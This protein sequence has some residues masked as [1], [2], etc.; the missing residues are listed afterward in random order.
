MSEAPQ[1]NPDSSADANSDADQ[2][3]SE[4][5]ELR[6]QSG[7]TE[8]TTVVQLQP[9]RYQLTMHYLGHDRV[10][11][12]DDYRCFYELQRGESPIAAFPELLQNV[13]GPSNTAT[14]SINAALPAVEGGTP[15]NPAGDEMFRVMIVDNHAATRAD[16]DAGFFGRDGDD[17]SKPDS[18]REHNWL[19]DITPAVPMRIVVKKYIGNTLVDFD[20][21]LKAIVEVKD[22][23][24]ELDNNAGQ[25]QT[26]LDEFFTKFN[27]TDNDPNIGDDNALSGFDGIRTG[28]ASEAG[29]KA[30]DVLRDV[31][32][33]SPPTID[34]APVEADLI[35]FSDLN[36]AP[37]H[38]NQRAKFTIVARD[39]DDGVKVGITDIAFV[40]APVGGDNYRFLIHLVCGNQDLRDTQEHGAA[41]T[42]V[43]QSNN[44][45]PK[46]QCYT[47]GRFVI[48][49]KADMRLIVMANNNIPEH[50]DWALVERIFNKS[51]LYVPE[52]PADR[53]VNLTRAAWRAELRRELD[54]GNTDPD[55]DNDANFTEA[56]YNTMFFPTA[57]HD[58]TQRRS[59]DNIAGSIIR[60]ACDNTSPPISPAPDEDTD[61]ESLPGLFMLLIKKGQN[62]PL[63]NLAGVYL[64]DRR[65]WF[66][67]LYNAVTDAETGV[68]TQNHRVNVTSKIY[69]HEYGHGL[70]L[71]HSHTNFPRARYTDTGGNTTNIRLTDGR[72]NN[73][74]RDHD[75]VDAYNCLMGYAFPST[76]V[77]CGLCS[78]TL[79]MFDRP[80]IAKRNNYGDESMAS[81]SPARVVHFSGTTQVSGNPVMNLNE[82]IPNLSV[83]STMDLI[84]CGPARQF[85]TGSS[86]TARTGRV[87]I[88]FIPDASTWVQTGG[89]SGSVSIGFTDTNGDNLNNRVRVTGVSPGVVT[90]RCTLDGITADGTFTVVE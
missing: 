53:F 15:E 88:S 16:A 4:S 73:N 17:W 70:Y 35:S 33:Q 86:N 48:W 44:I 2:Q 11:H 29:V 76:A 3:Q 49:K 14:E 32:Y 67:S 59:I 5:E 52:P 36:D 79:R 1:N 21:D 31:N 84:A 83:G 26:Y 89:G 30:T 90:V 6:S 78:L 12:C 28:S 81:L 87:N 60:H 69:A 85:A 42:V 19:R 27:R 68:V 71:R 20:A 65:F 37:S 57:I 7:A 41:V 22:P 74:L 72:R 75:Q 64:G 25:Q 66:A 62:S 13:V 56:I 39:N 24:E 45:I 38:A 63:G 61:Q 50:I 8:Q 82:T 55:F 23:V 34:H 40:P 58:I 18:Y 46:P 9:V 47:T 80:E 77:P 54:P 51:F 10:E 43:D